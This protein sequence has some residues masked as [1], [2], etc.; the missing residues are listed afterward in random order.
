MKNDA[1]IKMTEEAR[2]S[3]TDAMTTEAIKSLISST[4]DASDADSGTFSVVAST[5]DRDRQNEVVKQDGWDLSFYRL[6]PVILWAHD[7]GSLP[8]GA[9]T[10]IE[11]VNG[12]L[13][14]SGKFAPAAA[15]PVAQQIRMLYD[16][17][18]V[19]T[20]SVGFIPTEYD[21]ND[22]DVVTK[23][24]LLEIS[25]CPVPA[26]PYALSQR[27]VKE[28]GLDITMLKTKGFDFNIKTA[29][30]G[31]ACTMDDGSPGILGKDSKN[32]DGPMVCIPSKS[33]AHKNAV[34]AA[35]GDLDKAIDLFKTSHTAEK[36]M[37]AA[38]HLKAV[39]VFRDAL[40]TID[41]AKSADAVKDAFELH[42]K[43]VEAENQRHA[44]IMDTNCESVNK[45]IEVFKGAV[46]DAMKDYPND[47]S[48]GD[49]VGG[50]PTADQV[51][52]VKT[53]KDAYEH[54]SIA[55]TALKDYAESEGGNK[56]AADD[57]QAP[58]AK[59]ERSQA[60][61]ALDEMKTLEAN[62]EFVK[63][64]NII[65]GQV[66]RRINLRDKFPK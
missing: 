5:A 38:N 15:N 25:F 16:L 53:I 65:S 11:V 41:A 51:R 42:G 18:M 33:M 10:S 55:C 40:G 57:A 22:R 28:L 17:G 36:A 44:D 56:S 58:A 23:A 8:I 66:L 43:A 6:N 60:D 4:K 14:A 37:H 21:T 52:M 62:K 30:A 26:N 9:C 19:K 39:Q 29:E 64:I 27:Q 24:Q 54:M 34:S 32:P 63:T 45:C 35:L 61:S 3:F 1:L 48:T 59:V 31:D 20:V 47:P 7:Y 50:N 12:K 13:V 2:K 46:K 49:D